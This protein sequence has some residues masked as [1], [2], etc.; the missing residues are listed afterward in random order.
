MKQFTIS[1]LLGA[2]FMQLCYGTMLASNIVTVEGFRF[3]IDTD[4]NEATLL[5]ND[6]SGGLLYRKGGFGISTSY[7]SIGSNCFGTKVTS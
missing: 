7:N 4:E 6:Y 1:K 3:L 2:F 5:S